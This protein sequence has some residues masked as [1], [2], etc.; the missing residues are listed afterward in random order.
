[1]PTDIYDMLDNLLDLGWFVEKSFLTEP[2]IQDIK[3]IPLSAQR[4]QDLEGKYWFKNSGVAQPS[5]S[6]WWAGQLL[7][8]P[9]LT[10]A[11]QRVLD[12]SRAINSHWQ[13]Y[14]VDIITNEPT[15]RLV[16]PHVDSPY[17]F[18]S[19]CDSKELLALQYIIPLQAVD[20]NN[21]ATA[22]V[23]GSWR[24]TWPIECCY[25]HRFDQFF[26]ANCQQPQLAAGDCLIY[27]PN[28]LHSAMPNTSTGSRLA[29][30]ISVT[31]PG[32]MKRLK[33]VD[34][35]WRD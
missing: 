33:F 8:D 1:M 10:L 35:I 13:I 21:G 16:F 32:L 14:S 31:D 9:I 4:G 3:S 15:N 17:R 19:W 27:H 29:L 22:L 26:L 7:E 25:Q 2:E 23:P 11:K 5:L 12:H 30:L 24:Y 34:N 20:Q 6:L 28:M 18:E